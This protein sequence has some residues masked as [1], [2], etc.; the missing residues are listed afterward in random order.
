MWIAAEEIRNLQPGQ[1]V[2]FDPDRLAW[3]TGFSNAPRGNYQAMAVLDVNH[4]YAYNGLNPGDLRS[5]VLQIKDLDPRRTSSIELV[6]A[7]RID[8]AQIKLPSGSELLDFTSPLLSKFWGRPTH[9]RGIV[10]LPPSYA[11]SVRRYP[12][13]FA[14]GGFTLDLAQL[15]A[16]AP[17]SLGKGMADRLFPEMIHVVLD[18]SCPG[19]THEFADSV[20]NGPRGR[21]LTEE[22]VPYLESKYRMIGKPGGRLV[23]GG[24]SG[25][26]AVLWLQVNYPGTFGGA[27][28]IAPIRQTF[29]T[30]TEQIYMQIRRKIYTAARMERL[31]RNGYKIGHNRIVC[32]ATMAVSG[33]HSSRCSVHEGM[34]AVHSLYS[35]AIPVPL[36]L[37]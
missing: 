20:N 19:G 23:W 12:A 18:E 26:W 29:A 2:D 1:T 24:S 31:E 4:H 33:H 17:T 10:V 8:S 32:S 7:E 30:F 21:A 14:V 6:L 36:T 28:V 22:L 16:W 3:P 15:A 35:T 13:V 25:G 9:I 27:W 34:M 11:Q 37:L 5:R